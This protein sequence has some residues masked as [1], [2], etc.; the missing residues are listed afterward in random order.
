LTGV[1]IDSLVFTSAHPARAWAPSVL[2]Q[3][4]LIRAMRGGPGP[5]LDFRH[6]GN[7]ESR[8]TDILDL[9]YW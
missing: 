9:A 7:R 3:T 6:S 5:G 2:P 1:I 4:F 8:R